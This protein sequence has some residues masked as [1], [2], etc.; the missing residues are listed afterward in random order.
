MAEARRSRR[1]PARGH[2]ATAHEGAVRNRTNDGAPGRWIVTP[3]VAEDGG[4]SIAVLRGWIPLSV[5]DTTPPFDGVEPPS[6]EVEIT[7]WAQP[8]QTRGWLGPTDPPTGTLAEIA[9]LDVARIDQQ[10]PGGLEP[11]Y[12]QLE[13]QRP[14][15]KGAIAPV[16]LPTLD[17]G[18]HLGYALQWA[19]FTLI[20]IGG[21]PLI[22]RRQVRQRATADAIDANAAAGPPDPERDSDPADAASVDA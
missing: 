18:P 19:V 17:D 10:T 20:A 6:G 4:P 14:P 11:Y 21:Y 12:L 3:F 22:L 9:R 5:N 7:G 8:T 13:R 15:T 2:Y 1:V 16:P